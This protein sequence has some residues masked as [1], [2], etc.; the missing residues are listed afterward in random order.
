MRCY[1][2]QRLGFAPEIGGMDRARLRPSSAD[3][4]RLSAPKTSAGSDG[5]GEKRRWPAVYQTRILT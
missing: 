5:I 3:G 4:L 1:G 2:G